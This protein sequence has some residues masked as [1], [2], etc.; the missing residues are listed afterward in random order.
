MK[1][2]KGIIGITAALTTAGVIVVAI[3]IG[4]IILG[5]A[6]LLAWIVNYGLLVAGLL[7]VILGILAATRASN[8]MPIMIIVLFVGAFFIILHFSG[9]VLQEAWGTSYLSIDEIDNVGVGSEFFILATGGTAENL[10]IEWDVADINEY[11]NPEGYMVNRG[12]VADIKFTKW[13]HS[14]PI[15]LSINNFKN[16][17]TQDIV[18]YVGRES[19]CDL[20]DCYHSSVPQKGEYILIYSRSSP[21]ALTK[22]CV[23]IYAEPTAQVG[24]F[25]SGAQNLDYEIRFTVEGESATM[26]RN[27][28]TVSLNGG[29]FRAEYVGSL[30]TLFQL[31]PPG[32]DAVYQSGIYKGLIDS[33]AYSYK[34][35]DAP[36]TYMETCTGLGTTSIPNYNYVTETNVYNCL[37]QYSN[38]VSAAT[39][40]KTSEYLNSINGKSLTFSGSN[41]I[42]VSNIPTF[43]PVFKIF[44]NA[45]WVGLEELRGKPDITSCAEYMDISGGTQST[46]KITVKNVGTSD[47]QFDYSVTCDNSNAGFSGGSSFYI[48]SGSTKTLVLLFSGTNSNPSGDLTG[49]CTHKITDRKSGDYDTC[50]SNYKVKYTGEF[51]DPGTLKCNQDNLKELLVCSNDG[52]IWNLKETCEDKCGYENG[53]IKCLGTGTNGGGSSDEL[54]KEVCLARNAPGRFR[55]EWVEKETYTCGYNILCHIGLM[56]RT[57]SVEGRCVDTSRIYTIIAIAGGFLLLIVL[58][59]VLTRRR[60]GAS[61]AHYPAQTTVYHYG[62]SKRKGG[63]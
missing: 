62:S 24:K 19:S 39:Q 36:R 56:E 59:L 31:S 25:L 37:G 42:L 40:S 4:M 3:I 13:Q 52:L 12:I 34:G 49:T 46:T 22:E 55:Y 38:A 15:Q 9:V 23:C 60:P 5:I 61:Q 57:R 17:L 8:P 18:P 2:K 43:N 44:I 21:I 58:L 63:K 20:S 48:E 1:N 53:A 32:Y 54:S 6:G 14:F 33:G 29:R 47:G 16:I 41:A 11:V 35:I 50:V 7:V 27:S 45:N 51:C 10:R 28:P 26:S 30:G